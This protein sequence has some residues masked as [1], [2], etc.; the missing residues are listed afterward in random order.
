MNCNICVFAPAPPLRGESR[1]PGRLNIL[2]GERNPSSLKRFRLELRR[3]LAEIKHNKYLIKAD[4][5]LKAC[6]ASL[7]FARNDTDLKN[8]CNDTVGRHSLIAVSLALSLTLSSCA[9]ILIGGAAAV[10]VIVVTRD[11]AQ[12]TLDIEY[13]DM[14]QIANE[15][16]RNLGQLTSSSKWKGEI[17]GFVDGARVKVKIKK[18]TEKSV[19]IKVIAWRNVIPDTELS[20]QILSALVRNLT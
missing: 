4:K 8:V 19:H 16:I 11:F 3:D 15:E 7:R 1:G 10:G 13:A 17:V 14:W 12:T 18:L 6:F 5:L 20:K 9:P 2:G